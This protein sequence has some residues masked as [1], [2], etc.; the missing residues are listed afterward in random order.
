MAQF[1]VY[2]NATGTSD[3][4]PYLIDLQSELASVLETR[5]V[6]PLR[7]RTLIP[8]L[9]RALHPQV[10]VGNQNFVVSVGELSAVGIGELGSKVTNLADHRGEFIA[11]LDLLFTG[12]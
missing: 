5:L 2:R 7:P 11:A 4:A 3:E 9:V 8:W 6:A 10:K 1:D 12:I